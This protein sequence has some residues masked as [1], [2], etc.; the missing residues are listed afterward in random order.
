MDCCRWFGDF[1]LS[2]SCENTIVCWKPG[3]VDTK[4]EEGD[5]KVPENKVSIIHKIGFKDCEIWFVRFSM[6]KPQSLLAL[7]NQVGK[8]YV[9]D[10][11]V[12]E[13]SEISYSVLSHPK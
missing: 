12:E 3:T 5:S 11:K 6:D 10:M 8:T 9:W 1:V 13:P 2:K 4:A 7:G